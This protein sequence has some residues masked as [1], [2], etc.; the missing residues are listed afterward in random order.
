VLRHCLPA[1]IRQTL[2]QLP[3][4]LDDT[5][6][7]VLSQIPQANQAHAHRM[8]QCLVVAV[9]PLRVEELAELLAFEFDAPQGGIPKY[10]PALRLD[11]QTQAV[12]ST[13]SSLV[14]IVSDLWTGRQIVQFS[15]FSVKEFLVSN[16]LASSLGD[17]SRYHIRLES[18][19]TILTQACLGLL[20]H[21][22]DI[23]EKEESIEHSPLA[24]YAAEHWVEHA[25]FEDVASRVKDGMEMLFDSD[26][27]HFEAW[28]RIYNIDL[29]SL[30][31]ISWRIQI[32]CTILCFADFMTWLSTSPS[33]IPIMSMLAVASTSFHCLLHWAKA[34]SRL[35][36][37]FLSMAQ[38]PMRRTMKARP[39]CTYCQKTISMT[40]DDILDLVQLLLK[41]GA[42][43]NSRTEIRHTPLH[44]AI[45]RN[46]FKLA[47]ILLEHG[48]DADAAENN[49]G[50]TPLHILS[51]RAISR[52]QADLLNLV[53]LLLKHGAAVNNRTKNRYTPLH[54][55]IRRNRFKLAEILLEHGADA[56]AE[57]ING[58]TP[59]HI[60]S[61]S[62][63]EDAGDL[64]N[65][66]LLLLKHGA[67]VNSR[68]QEVEHSITSGNTI[69]IGSS[70]RRSFSSMVQMPLL[71]TTRR[72]PVA[73]IVRKRYQGHRQSTQSRAVIIEA[74]CSSEQS[75]Q[76]G[77]HSVTSGNTTESV[78][79]CRDPS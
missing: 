79:A 71:R 11:D 61:E 7:R 2:K 14:T 51:E 46:R 32:L 49:D 76:D 8:L 20:L 26:K 25:Q 78:Q 45:Y 44:L 28:V 16:R 12:L 52:T 35:Q 73:H 59:L 55:A 65:L 60:L 9:R 13:C 21:S 53:L 72:D 23:T 6:L 41:H 4:S 64:L 54:L 48:A 67:A 33:N 69:G 56:H 3:K 66:V 19:H 18:A 30:C 39:H 42:A 50:Q 63:I 70:L 31:T 38:M 29:G 43:V 62:D 77:A 74:W 5:Y 58:Q 24:R 17:I 36:N 22:D 75:N 47:E 15:H 10:R 40:E 37:S 27:P 34:T 57:N 1:S 68:R